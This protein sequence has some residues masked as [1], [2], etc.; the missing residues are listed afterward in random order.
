MHPKSECVLPAFFTDLD[1]FWEPSWEVKSKKIDP[2][3]HR[4]N[5]AKKKGTWMSKKSQKDPIPPRG[6][7]GPDPRRGGRGRGKPFP[8]GFL[9]SFRRLN[10]LSPEGWWD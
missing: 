9:G 6:V 1:R 8:R 2:R 5:N 10:H 3:R 7:P 4:K